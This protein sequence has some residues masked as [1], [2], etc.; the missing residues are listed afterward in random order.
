MK[1]A[2]ESTTLTGATF[3]ELLREFIVRLG[4]GGIRK[5]LN[6][7]DGRMEWW[8]NGRR[9]CWNTGIMDLCSPYYSIIPTFQYSIVHPFQFSSAPNSIYELLPL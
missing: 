1:P 7:N 6:L 4:E 8:N 3:E 9:K 2:V 5:T